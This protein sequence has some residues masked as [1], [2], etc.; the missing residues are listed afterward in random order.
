M[1]IMIDIKFES[2]VYLEF[3]MIVLDNWHF[4]LLF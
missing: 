3:L 2:N 1:F 4:L